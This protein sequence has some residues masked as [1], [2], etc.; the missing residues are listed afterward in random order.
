ME[1]APDVL[2]FLHIN[3]T[4]SDLRYESSIVVHTEEKLLAGTPV[5]VLQLQALI[6]LL[7]SLACKLC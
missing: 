2:I 7:A 5:W 3:S 4:E 6:L 1:P